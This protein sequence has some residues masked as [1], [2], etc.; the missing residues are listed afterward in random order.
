MAALLGELFTIEKDFAPD[1]ERQIAGLRLLLDRPDDTVVFVARDAAGRA[2]A[3]VAAQ[4]VVSTSEGALSVWIED[5]VVDAAH[6]RR[7]IGSA[8]LDA[9]LRW[10]RDRGAT[11]AQLLIDTEN[12]PAEAFYA[13]LGW[14][15]TQLAT[16]RLMLK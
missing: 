10:A 5:V 16:R 4:L 6:R 1:V 8:L 2:V 7:G 15:M 3:L 12:T 13:R 11:R 14:R 9:A